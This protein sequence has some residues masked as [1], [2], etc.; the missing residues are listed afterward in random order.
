MPFRGKGP[1]NSDPYHSEYGNERERNP[2]EEGRSTNSEYLPA[3][4]SMIGSM[5]L[6]GGRDISVVAISM[7]FLGRGDYIQTFMALI[8]FEAHQTNLE[9]GQ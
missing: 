6:S 4:C 3:Y 1:C 5:L 7:I 9:L 8:N 2:Q